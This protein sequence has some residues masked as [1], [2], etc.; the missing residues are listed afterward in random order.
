MMPM[1]ILL[2]DHHAALT[3]AW[4]E[5]F[6]EH[7]EVTVVHGDFFERDAD[8]MVSPAN[9]FG[10]MD[11]GID[12]AIRRELG[13]TIQ[14]VVQKLILEKHHGELHVGAAEIVE[15]AHVRWPFLVVAPTMRVPESV[16]NTLN[17]Y[18]AFRA[19]LLAVMRHNEQSPTKLIRSLL[20][21]GLGTGIGAMDPRRCAAQ[22]RLALDQVRGPA[23]IPSYST[24]RALHQKL[25]TAI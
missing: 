20:V 5:V 19:I 3:R 4:S 1:E 18:V 12:V 7:E 9:S 10:I 15:T 23:R 24:I 16:A 17:A 8:A 11:G 21:P 2:V 6:A 25:R 22:M 13:G 14:N